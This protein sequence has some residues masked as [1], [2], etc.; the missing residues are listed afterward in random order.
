VI[1]VCDGQQ[2]VSLD[3]AGRAR[4]SRKLNH[5]VRQMACSPDGR[6]V[7]LSD[8]DIGLIRVY[9]G[10]DLTLIRQRF[11]IDLVLH[12]TQVQLMA[13]IPPRNVAP[14]MLRIDNEGRFA[15]SMAGVVCVSDLEQF[16]QLPA[17]EPA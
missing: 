10:S 6:L 13:E 16:D 7:V 3:S 2:I 5:T 17:A 11:A 1:Y 14:G 12:A 15:L 9:R 8:M 4:K